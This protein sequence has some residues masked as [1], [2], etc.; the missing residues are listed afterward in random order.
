MAQVFASLH[1][2]AEKQVSLEFGRHADKAGLYVRVPATLVKVVE[3]QLAA[4]YPDIAIERLEETAIAPPA[5]GQLHTTELWLAGDVL[6]I[7]TCEAFEDRL[8]RELNDPLAGVLGILAADPGASVWSHVA[9]ALSPVPRRRI[10]TARR[11]LDRFYNT[12][13]HANH[14]LGQWFL[15]LATSPNPLRRIAARFIASICYQHAALPPIESKAAYRKLDQPLYTA[16]IRLTT[17]AAA[18]AAARRQLRQ[19]AAAFAPYTINSRAEFRM[20]RPGR[21]RRGSLLS[22]EELAILFHPVTTG[23]R[24]ERM[25]RIE[26]RALE[27]P[28]LLPSV[29][30]AGAVVLGMTNFRRRRDQVAMR[31][32]DRRKHL[33]IVGKTGT[34]KSTLLLNLIAQDASQGRGLAVIEPHGDLISDILQRIPRF[35]TNDVILFDPA[36]HAI[37]FNPLACRDPQQR[38]L[39]AAGVLSAMKKVFAI[40]ETNAPRMLY[41]LRNVL[42][43][44]VEQP[45]ATLV[46]IPRIL[47]DEPFRRR[48]VSR[49]ADPLVKSFWENEFAGWHD[50]YRV[51]AIAPIQNKVGQFL[52]SPIIRHVFTSSRSSLDIRQAMDTGKIL[53]VNLSHGRLGDDSSAL[54]GA[55]LVTALE[56]AA[57]SRA[58]MPEHQRR[59]FYLYADEFQTYAGT[60]SLQVILSQARKYRLSLCLANQLVEQMSPDLAATVF[61]N[62]GSLCVMQVGRSDAQ[63]LAEELGPDVLPQDLTSLP[64]YSAVVRILIDGE[65]TRP[66]TIRTQPPPAVTPRH[67]TVKKLIQASTGRYASRAA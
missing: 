63:R 35:R 52:T 33:Y 24:A 66:F 16:H 27:P 25:E 28:A 22:I 50:R 20:L 19:L 32:D 38:P 60:E 8:S 64:K 21:N 55:L 11:I 7:E 12:P 3:Q 13:L 39:V 31:A 43:A 65:P 45:E 41:I 1:Q 54:L 62:V 23:V 42:L 6:P 56:Q 17:A 34:G 9:I 2:V 67:A 48:I 36:E 37:V 44:L 51:E 14:R 18:P 59:D 4:A 40:D 61:G 26:S 49:L 53:L 10:R 58:D 57:K 15:A 47:V 29:A 5:A 46:D 30:E